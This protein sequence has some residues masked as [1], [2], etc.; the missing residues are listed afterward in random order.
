MRSAPL[1]LVLAGCML[2][3]DFEV[4]E[5]DVPERFLDEE[6]AG[7]S[8]ANMPWWEVFQDKELQ[9]LIETALAQ[10]LDISI[11]VSRIA[12]ARAA[13]G[14]VKADQYPSLRYSGV[15]ARTDLGDETS[16]GRQS[17]SNDFR[18]GP[19]AFFEI[20]LWGKLRRSTEAARAELLA[21][22]KSCSSSSVK[23]VS[24]KFSAAS[25]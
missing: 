6:T 2:G 10:N 25:E 9:N 14:F 7:K 18:V 21:T 8:I 23:S 1:L 4:P 22:A 5:V 16:L 12:E 3:P 19:D 15:A 17:P 24:R 20:D 11:A 13:L